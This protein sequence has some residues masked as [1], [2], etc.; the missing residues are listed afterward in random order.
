[1]VEPNLMTERGM[2]DTLSTSY[3]L[4]LNLHTGGHRLPEIIV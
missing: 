1:M 2:I 4:N 3:Y